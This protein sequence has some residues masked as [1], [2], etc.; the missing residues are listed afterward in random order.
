MLIRRT[1]H[2]LIIKLI[3]WT[4][5]QKT[6]LLSLIKTSLEDV[7][8]STTLSNLLNLIKRRCFYAQ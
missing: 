6:K 3:T 7:Y 4:V 5:N 8:Y 2:D 1:K